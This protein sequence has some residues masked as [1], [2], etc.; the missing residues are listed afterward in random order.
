MA[1]FNFLSLR[2]AP[3]SYFPTL[4]L[5]LLSVLLLSHYIFRTIK[6]PDL[7]PALVDP[8]VHQTL[9]AVDRMHCLQVRDESALVGKHA[10]AQKTAHRRGLASSFLLRWLP[11]FSLSPGLF[12]SGR[13]FCGG[14][15][16]GCSSTLS[17]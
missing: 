15:E 16:A 4:N 12:L 1:L 7:R 9:R 2:I 14:T 10:G 3:G 13:P 5:C 11:S 17:Q 8:L 6:S